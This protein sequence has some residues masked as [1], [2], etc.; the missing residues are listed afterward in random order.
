MSKG[1]AFATIGT[2]VIFTWSAVQNGKITSVAKDILTGEKP[3]PGPGEASSGSGGSTTTAGTSGLVGIALQYIGHPYLFG[4]A[5]GA[6][7]ESPWDCSS[8]MNYIV[9]VKANLAI[10]GYPAGT[11]LGLDHGPATGSWIIWNGTDHISA[12]QRQPGDLVVGVTH[13]GMF[14]GEYQ[15][16]SDQYISA[17]DPAEGTSVKSLETFPDP[18]IYYR[19]VRE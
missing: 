2:G 1:L 19:R 7:G 6:D 13:M 15:G 12:S 18:L 4:G 5:P 3:S 10:P 16:A 8:A 11:Y 14:V 9:G 17:H